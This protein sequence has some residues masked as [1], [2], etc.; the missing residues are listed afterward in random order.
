MDDDWGYHYD[1]SE[2][3][4]LVRVIVMWSCTRIIDS[5]VIAV[6]WLCDSDECNVD[7]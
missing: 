3:T 5:C 4:I 7:D 1:L 2:T 6:Y